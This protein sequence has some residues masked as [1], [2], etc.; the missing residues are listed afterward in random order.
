MS[1]DHGYKIKITKPYINIK[2]KNFKTIF[3]YK[4]YIITSH[5]INQIIKSFSDNLKIQI[6]C[7]K[8][9]I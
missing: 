6:K 1:K 2:E 8:S 3:K 4:I 7:I 5:H 9:L